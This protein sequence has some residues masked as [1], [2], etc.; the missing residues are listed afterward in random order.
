MV[1]RFWRY[2]DKDEYNRQKAG[3]I[4]KNYPEPTP[5]PQQ[6]PRQP[7]PAPAQVPV[8]PQQPRPNLLRPSTW[9]TTTGIPA[10]AG[11]LETPLF[12]TLVGQIAGPAVAA[13]A[14]VPMAW[15]RWLSSLSREKVA[16]PLAGY[17]GQGG[18]L[19]AMFDPEEK[20]RLATNWADILAGKQTWGSATAETMAA[21]RQAFLQTPM[22]GIERAAT[23]TLADP[24][25]IGGAMIAAPFAGAGGIAGALGK[26]YQVADITDMAAYL[27]SA[28]PEE[29][30]GTALMAGAAKL[31][32]VVIRGAAE[33]IPKLRKLL[34]GEVGAVEM[35]VGK[36]PEGAKRALATEVQELSLDQINIDPRKYQKRAIGKEGIGFREE[37]VKWI[38]EHWDPDLLTPVKVRRLPDGT[39]DLLGGHHRMEVLKRKGISTT[40]AQV[41][42][43]D[44]LEAQ[45]I[46]GIDN[47]LSEGYEDSEW[48]A[49]VR[50]RADAGRSVAEIADEFGIKRPSIAEQYL[51]LSY[52]PDSLLQAVD[53]GA[54]PRRV[55][56][57]L[58]EGAQNYGVG[59][60]FLQ[61]LWLREIK[62]SPK[63]W[64]ATDVRTLLERIAPR[65]QAIEKQMGMFGEEL[66]GKEGQRDSFFAAMRE[67][68][69]QVKELKL[70]KTRLSGVEREMAKDRRVGKA[71]S[72]RLEEA[73][74]LLGQDIEAADAAIRQIEQGQLDRVM[75]QARP[76]LE[77]RAQEAR[78]TAREVEPGMFTGAEARPVFGAEGLPRRVPEAAPEAMRPMEVS[79]EEAARLER[80][81]QEAAGQRRL[82]AA[83]VAGGIKPLLAAHGTSENPSAIAWD[84]PSKASFKRLVGMDYSDANARKAWAWFAEEAAPVG[85]VPE[86]IVD[87]VAE[88]SGFVPAVEDIQPMEGDTFGRVVW[89]DPNFPLGDIIEMNELGVIGASHSSPYVRGLH[90]TTD[91]EYWIR[92]L[93]EDYA[94]NPED[95]QIVT[96]RAGPGD[97]LV[98][99]PQY[100]MPTE[101]MTEKADSWIL[102]STRRT[103]RR[104]VDFVVGDERFIDEITGLE[105][106][107][108]VTQPITPAGPAA[109][110]PGPGPVV[111]PRPA[112]PV[113]GAGGIPG[114]PLVPPTGEAAALT[115]VPPAAGQPWPAGQPVQPPLAG[116]GVQITPGGPP[117]GARVA[118]PIPPVAAPPQGPGIAL[119]APAAGPAGPSRFATMLPTDEILRLS[120]RP[121]NVRKLMDWAEGTPGNPVKYILQHIG[122]SGTD[123]ASEARLLMGTIRADGNTAVMGAVAN[124]RS[125]GDP[126]KLFNV[127]DNIA[128]IGGKKL[129]IGDLAEGKVKATLTA[130]QQAFIDE[131][132]AYFDDLDRLAAAEGIDIPKAE[133]GAGE[134]YWARTVM[135]RM[136][137]DGTMEAATIR[138]AP[139]GRWLTALAGFEKPRE[140]DTMAEA[141]AEGFR[142]LDLTDAAEISGR[143][144]YRRIANQRVLDYVLANIPQRVGKKARYGEVSLP[145]IRGRY[146]AP[147]EDILGIKNLLQDSPLTW[148]EEFADVV[149]AVNNVP[150]T[151]TTTLDL[152]PMFA[153]LYGMLTNWPKQWA[154][155][156]GVGFKSA[157]TPENMGKFLAQS[158]HAATVNR[159]APYGLVASGS[160]LTVGAQGF[161]GKI[162]LVGKAVKTGARI[163]DNMMMAARIMGLEA[164][165][166]QIKKADDV[167]DLVAFWNKFTGVVETG[168]QG[169]SRRQ[170]KLESATLFAPRLYRA[171][172]SLLLDIAHGDLRGKMA[173]RSLGQMAAVTLLGY[174][175]LCGLLKQKARVDP[176]EGSRWLTIQV[177]DQYLGIR[178]ALFMTLRTLA[179]IGRSPEDAAELAQGYI[180]GRFSPVVSTSIDVYNR[181]DF[182]GMP[183]DTPLQLTKRIVADNL[184]PFW[185]QGVIESGATDWQNYVAVGSA[186]L[187]GLRTFPVSPARKRDALRDEL[188]Q[189]LFQ[190][191]WAELNRP[192]K[193]RLEQSPDL[194]A[195]TEAAQAMGR[196]R[197]QPWALF[198]A[199]VD[200]QR[201]PYRTEIAQLTQQF[202]SNQLTGNQYREAVQERQMIMARIPDM[203]RNTKDYKDIDF[204]KA[205]A[206]TPIDQFIDAYYQIADQARDPLTGMAD[207]REIVR[208]REELKQG[209]DAAMVREAMEY[210]NRNLDPQY[211]E[212]RDLYY[213]Y[214]RIPQYIG[215]SEEQA[216]AANEAM[217]KYTAMRRANP[218][219]P[220]ET[221]KAIYRQQDPRGAVLMEMAYS[222]RNP[223]RRMFWALHPLLSV[224]YSDLTEEEVEMIA[225]M[226]MPQQSAQLPSWAMAAVA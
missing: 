105:A 72:P 51:S 217:A 154:Q 15:Q 119:A 203:L 158:D 157:F 96:L 163:F 74:A 170:Q 148:P 41:F 193:S 134:H 19:Q 213:E 184:T 7:M 216:Q 207:A 192:Q 139:G 138:G 78:P 76:P 34:A 200:S 145:G 210:I 124:L 87:K 20:Q 166:Y 40:Q 12:Q 204:S 13:R 202:R 220:T 174:V 1:S 206:E 116:A 32:P 223:A 48:A 133:Y 136:M 176:K 175:G 171:T 77:M 135:G 155:A 104:G 25:G 185:V 66:P 44:M 186:E 52:L 82:E 38:E 218:M 98:E 111:A 180:R 70:R 152:G 61:Q 126:D 101:G 141:L 81:Q 162:P 28:T 79:P 115:G 5:P 191:P 182:I 177:G 123:P 128:S 53:I 127:K 55:A 209:M 95:A 164:T 153:Q 24:L 147:T 69:S 39:F 122:V 197:E 67:M 36:M 179:Q 183:I 150:R 159:Y 63:E 97:L 156:V 215:L 17:L 137:P 10:D 89:D 169:I 130:D 99:D 54:L 60:E 201:E 208:Q 144:I 93:A 23:T 37:R 146:F 29:L 35:P 31:A 8:Q 11:G 100:A 47:M 132:W 219:L 16:E 59:P 129:P 21:N 107:A 56:I 83:R 88:A 142:Y 212:A 2:Q 18:P 64:T 102:L 75:A 173:R 14:E 118:G 49:I 178:G 113:G 4:L 6:A 167:S 188:A 86:G 94:R 50:G 80:A 3:E 85:P 198:W 199:D 195:A 194:K 103:L 149:G 30:A 22:S 108:P 224:F 58:G 226:A 196:K 189:G 43:V 42:D 33:G 84:V 26:A 190:K 73:A 168:A 27:A 110:P 161:L 143:A 71:V 140:F 106:E 90:V 68:K 165:E 172:A 221:T 211:V 9:P 214:M 92:T 125:F 91:P 62:A 181:R 65:A 205:A 131:G 45:H 46:A 109:P 151:L 160:E 57:A 114:Q 225:P 117:A 187:A 120:E 112:Q 121:D 222:R